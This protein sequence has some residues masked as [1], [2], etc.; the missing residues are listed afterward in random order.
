MRTVK[1]TK[2]AGFVRTGVLGAG[3]LLAVPASLLPA[4]AASADSTCY[5]GCTTNTV[6]TTIPPATSADAGG[7]GSTPAPATAPAGGLAFTGADISEMAAVGG[8]TVL[9]GMALVVRGRRRRQVE[10]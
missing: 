8:G 6:V 5:T 4:T 2:S 10:A 1:T 7:G 9:V 3:L